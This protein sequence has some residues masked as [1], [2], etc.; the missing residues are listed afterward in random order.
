MKQCERI[1]Y[2]LLA[3]VGH[4]LDGSNDEQARELWKHFYD[5]HIGTYQLKRL[6]TF[7]DIINSESSIEDIVM[8][9]ETRKYSLDFDFKRKPV[10]H[11]DTLAYLTEPFCTVNDIVRYRAVVSTLRNKKQMR[12]TPE[13]VEY[14]Q[15]RSKQNIRSRGT[16]KEDCLRHFLRALTQCVYPFKSYDGYVAVLSDLKG[17]GATMD[18][19]KNARRTP[20]S[21]QVVFNNSANRTYI[22]KMLKSL[23]Y[24]STDKYQEWVDL[25]IHQ[26]LSNPVTMFME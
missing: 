10:K 17:Y 18:K 12:S 14:Y 8:L 6:S 3:K 15:A 9:S 20:F 25:L 4:K 26:G 19:L 7:R 2:P 21:A 24:E 23:G 13:L 11:D 5:E 1:I 16:G 22:R